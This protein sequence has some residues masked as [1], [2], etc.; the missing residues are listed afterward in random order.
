MITKIN[1]VE[2]N[3]LSQNKRT[4]FKSKIVPNKMLKDVFSNAR[5]SFEYRNITKNNMSLMFLEIKLLNTIKNILNDGK[6]N[7]IEFTASKNGKLGYKLNGKKANINKTEM[8]EI[9]SKNDR[10]IT[11]D[12]FE[13]ISSAIS[14]L[15]DDLNADYEAKKLDILDNLHKN[16]QEID[17]IFY[18]YTVETL[19]QLEKQIFKNK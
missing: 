1:G 4:S 16:I 2:N 7:L 17:N 6:N 5:E 10:T 15:K 12:Q 11:N 14:K 18:K 19:N 9:A 3:Y 8:H 13:I